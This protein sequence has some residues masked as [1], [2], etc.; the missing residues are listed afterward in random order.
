LMR[1]FDAA[2]AGSLSECDLVSALDIIENYFVRRYLI[3]ETQYVNR[4]FPTLC[5]DIQHY[6]ATLPATLR[7][8]L[9]TKR[10]P[11][12]DEVR[13]AARKRPL[14]V[15]SRTYSSIRLRALL[16]RINE[17]LSRDC[18]AVT[19]LQGT[20][21]IEHILPQTLTDA[22]RRDLGDA[23]EQILHDY[24][25]TL[26]NLTLVTQCY[27]SQ[28][29]NRSFAEKARELAH[30]GLKLNDVYFADPPALW[31]AVAIQQRADFLVD[32]ILAIW[33]SLGSDYMK[34]AEW[35]TGA[36]PKLL[37]IRDEVIP[38]KL[39]RDIIYQTAEYCIRQGAFEAVA[40]A[41]PKLVSA[42]KIDGKYPK[43]WTVLSNHWSVKVNMSRE[44]VK[45]VC[46]RIFS[47][48]GV[49]ENEWHIEEESVESTSGM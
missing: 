27:N 31:N 43:D 21:T 4:M 19:V 32:Q 29:S 14:Y 9:A 13:A 44:Q 24:G 40:Q 33:P 6:D 11:T 22:W 39:W 48:I 45:S 38:V 28:L 25:D 20:P 26:G 12:D 1:L 3:G 41:V 30:H 16:T 47:A 7:A 46:R 8:L 17:H 49:S 42:E 35:Q 15:Q 18:D 5:R 37:I 10:C 36:K 34:R 23:A 2:D